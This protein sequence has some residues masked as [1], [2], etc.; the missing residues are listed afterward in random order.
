MRSNSELIFVPIFDCGCNVLILLIIILHCYYLKKEENHCAK[1]GAQTFFPSKRYLRRKLHKNKE[2][3]DKFQKKKCLTNRG[4]FYF[5]I[6]PLGFYCNASQRP[7]WQTRKNDY[8]ELL[9]N[10]QMVIEKLKH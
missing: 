1:I 7:N 9:F 6:I 2:V 4:S 10:G 8:F 5:S 3:H